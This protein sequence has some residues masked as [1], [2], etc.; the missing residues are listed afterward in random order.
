MKKCSINSK[1]G[2]KRQ[3]NKEQVGQIESKYQDN[4]VKSNHINKLTE[5]KWFGQSLSNWI[6]KKEKARPN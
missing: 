2:I 6:L 5:N 4:R 1:E 3:K